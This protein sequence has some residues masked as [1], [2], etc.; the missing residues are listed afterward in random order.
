[1]TKGQDEFI[2]QM[3]RK[4]LVGWC[5]RALRASDLLVNIYEDEAHYRDHALAK[6]W[7][8]APTEPLGSYKILAAGWE[9]SSRFLKR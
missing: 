6:K 3:T 8:S 5:D 4:A 7:I 2:D 1:M 9:T